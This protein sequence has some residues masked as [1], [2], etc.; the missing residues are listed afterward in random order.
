VI[1][2]SAR[3]LGAGEPKYLNSPETPLFDKGRT[4]FNIDRAAAASREARR[5]IVV[6]GQMDVIA[7][8]QAGIAEA[9]AP[10]GTA[11]TETQL[12]LLWRCRRRR[13]S[14]STATRP[15]RKPRSAGRCGR[16]RMSVLRD[17]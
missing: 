14:A 15:G 13:S 3:I 6:E 12:E 17:R 7:L 16:C 2:F 5:V 10:L 1:A 8:D 11:M 9:V 4:L